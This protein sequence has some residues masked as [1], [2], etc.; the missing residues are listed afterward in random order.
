MCSVR[1]ALKLKCQFSTDNGWSIF[2]AI[3]V[4]YLCLWRPFWHFF[5]LRVGAPALDEPYFSLKC[6]ELLL[7]MIQRELVL[8]IATL[9]SKEFCSLMIILT[10]Y[11]CSFF[12]FFYEYKFTVENKKTK[13]DIHQPSRNLRMPGTNLKTIKFNNILFKTN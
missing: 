7:W 11:W 1:H 9:K 8:C 10:M 13:K 4:V 6:F 3:V 5:K 2:F 12:V